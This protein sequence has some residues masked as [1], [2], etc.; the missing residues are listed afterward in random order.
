MKQISAEAVRLTRECLA[1][2]WQGD[3]E[4][5]IKL[6]AEDVI[7]VGARQDEFK[8]G[9]EAVAADLRKTARSI[10]TCHLV[11][12]EFLPVACGTKQCTVV[13]RYLVTADSG[14]DFM[15]AQQR[16]TFVWTKTDQG[17]RLRHL[18]ISNPM[19][20][21]KLAKD[22]D[23]PDT[24]GRMAHSYMMN[25]YRN[26]HQ[27]TILSVLGDGGS[28]HFLNLSDVLFITACG[29]CATVHTVHGVIPVKSSIGDLAAQ[30]KGKLLS[31]HR[32]H[33]VNPFYISTVQRYTV[34]MTNG[35]QLPIPTRKFNEIRDALL[36]LHSGLEE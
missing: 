5:V 34:I 32:S 12:A 2:F 21:L 16:C 26:L 6:L 27:A 4:Y 23:F 9:D 18:H 8:I 28:L 29:K 22:E 3:V 33:L 25:Y 19:G 10:R 13:G 1:H 36:H 17:C 24:V 11:D 15:Q 35:E 20:E 30:T 7:W 31:I 14:E